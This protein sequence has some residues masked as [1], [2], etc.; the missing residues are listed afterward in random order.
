MT[1]FI[2]GIICIILSCILLF[3]TYKYKNRINILNTNIA[4][5]NYML[6]LQNQ[7]LKEKKQ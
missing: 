1:L 2:I 4:N 5:E 3:Y 6:D 7:S